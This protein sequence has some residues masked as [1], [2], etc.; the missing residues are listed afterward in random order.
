MNDNWLSSLDAWKTTPPDEHEERDICPDCDADLTERG[1]L[2]C[3][4]SPEAEYESELDRA[5]DEERGK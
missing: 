1:C 5:I 4:W 2:R 3:G